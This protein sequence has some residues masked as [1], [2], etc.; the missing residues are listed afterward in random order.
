MRADLGIVI[1]AS[2]NPYMDN[3]IKLFGADGFKLPDELEADIEKLMESDTLGH[4]TTGPGIGRAEKFEDSRGRYVSFVKGTFPRELTLEGLRVA[5]DAAHGAAY[6]VAPLVFQELGAH[7]IAIGVKPNGVNINKDAG[8]LHPDNL[9]AE[10][11]KRSCDVGIALDGDAD[12]LI[13]VD[14]KGQIVDGDVV[15]ALCGAALIRE[16]KL[17]KKTLVATVMSNLGLERYL[18]GLGL[19]LHRV[20]V[21]DRYVLE[22]MHSRGCNLGGEQSGHIILSDFTTTGDGLVAALQVLAHM[23]ETGRALSDIGRCFEP[24]P[25][26]LRNVRYSNGSPLGNPAVARAIAEAERRL[27]ATGRLLIRPSGTEPVIRVMAEG[28]DQRLVAEVVDSLVG[29]LERAA[30]G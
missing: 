25:Q 16:G 10:V 6:R 12:R 3:G 17:A 9:R 11:V 1:S 24:V 30:A 18:A 2:H 23:A 5:V 26:T 19:D 27:A 13:V 22:G 15:M 20:A 4:R 28:S 21:G 7:L 8:A 29:A 14:E